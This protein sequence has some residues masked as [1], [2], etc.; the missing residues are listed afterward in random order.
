MTVWH[1]NIAVNCP[2]P[3]MNLRWLT[4]FYAQKPNH[5]VL[6]LLGRMWNVIRYIF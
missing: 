5:S 6:I 1:T 3:P 2:H 4:A